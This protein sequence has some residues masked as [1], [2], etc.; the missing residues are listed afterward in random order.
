M[1]KA[2][3]I[4]LATIILAGASY[5]AFLY[6]ATYSEGVRAG[7]L[8]KVNNKG[9]I[10]KTWEVEIRSQGVSS[11]QVFTF[12]ALG[13]DK[14]LIDS[15]ETLQ[16][17]YVKVTYIERYRT[18]PWWGDTKYFITNVKS[19]KPPFKNKKE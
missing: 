11:T 3:I 16:N 18:F 4:T 13:N 12:S 8:I 19:E 6:Y 15:L 17:Q 14:N 2:L 9:V 1:K 5:Y 10:F 7:E